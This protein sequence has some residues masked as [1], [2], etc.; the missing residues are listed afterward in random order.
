MS[1]VLGALLGSGGPPGVLASTLSSPSNAFS[2]TDTVKTDGQHAY[3]DGLGGEATENWVTPASSAVAANYEVMVHVT[4]G[5]FG[6]GT[7]DTWLACTTQRAWS[8]SVA[9]TVLYE[10]SF[11]QVN[12]PT[13]KTYTLSMVVT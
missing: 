6:A 8:K 4:S 13:L 2:A 10:M 1:G 3:S 7:L 5:T 9:G 11:R 12:G